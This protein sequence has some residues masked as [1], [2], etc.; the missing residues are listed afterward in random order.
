MTTIIY[1]PHSDKNFGIAAE[2]GL[3]D[4]FGITRTKH[5]NSSYCTNSDICVGNMAISVKASGFSL[6]S[7]K[8][9]DGCKDF[10][11]I[12]NIYE[13]RV[14]SNVFAYCTKDG[15]AYMMNIAE[16]KQF[17]YAFCALERESK[18]NGGGV[19][20]RCRKESK[21][22]LAWLNMRVAA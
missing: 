22:M 20:I 5:D 7:A 4:V 16:F 15:V 12:W 9:C 11:G 19:K 2:H 10:D 17:V 8:L 6:M 13:S 3:C 21:K 18:K 14:H 1:V